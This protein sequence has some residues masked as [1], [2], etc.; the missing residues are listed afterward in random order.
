MVQSNLDYLNPF[1]QGEIWNRSDK[2]K[3]TL[4]TSTRWIMH[5]KTYYWQIY[6][7]FW[8]FWTHPRLI[9]RLPCISF[10]SLSVKTR[11]DS[12]ATADSHVATT[13]RRFTA[14]A[15][16]SHVVT[17]CTLTLNF[18]CISSSDNRGDCIGR[19]WHRRATDNYIPI[20]MWLRYCNLIGH[21][22]F[23]TWGHGSV[24]PFHQTFSPF[25]RRRGWARD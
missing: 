19:A 8:R 5:A 2:Q 22:W 20:V 24:I 14:H 9:E 21:V 13:R 12:S 3:L 25:L 11:F 18:L 4:T 7:S 10:T 23:S 17:M 15:Q 16:F 1:G 6:R